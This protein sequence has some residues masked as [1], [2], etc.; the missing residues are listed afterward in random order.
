MA[1]DVDA[2]RCHLNAITRRVEH[3]HEMIEDLFFS[4]QHVYAREPSMVTK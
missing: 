1:I 4:H 2:I 3:L